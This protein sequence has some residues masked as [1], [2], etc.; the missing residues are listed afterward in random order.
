MSS[1]VDRVFRH[2]FTMSVS[3]CSG[4]DFVTKV[5]APLGVPLLSKSTSH[6][7]STLAFVFPVTGLLPSYQL[8][9]VASMRIFVTPN[10]HTLISENEDL[11]TC[12]PM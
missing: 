2:P 4:V 1:H 3:Q 7:A 9:A 6:F 12:I 8:I 10:V 5:E 11:Y